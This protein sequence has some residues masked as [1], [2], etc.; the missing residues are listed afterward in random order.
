MK[1]VCSVLLVVSLLLMPLSA[2][3][4][5]GDNKDLSIL[6]SST[7]YGNYADYTAARLTEL[8]GLNINLEYNAKAHEVLQPQIIAGNP[9]DVVMAQQNFFDYFAAI[10][11][12]A[13]TPITKYLELPVEDSDQTVHAMANAS[14]IDSM[15]VNGEAYVMMSNMNISGICYDKAMFAKHGWAV[16]QSWDEFIALC[17]TIKTTTDIAPFIYPGMYPYYMSQFF[18]P[19]IAAVGRGTES[20]KDINN[21]K[22]GIWLS[23]EVRTSADRL[24]QMRDKGYFAKDLLSLNHT[25][26][27]MEFINGRVAMVS[28]GSWI[29]NEMGDN[30]PE[31]FELGFMVNPCGNAPDSEK[32]VQISGTLMGFP[33]AAKNHDWIG[34]FLQTYYSPASAVAVANQCAVVISPTAVTESAALRAALTPFVAECFDTTAQNTSIFMIYTIWYSEFFAGLQNQLTALISGE[35][36]APVFCE[37]M[38]KLAQGVRDDDFIAKYTLS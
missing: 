11:A 7:G 18:F 16:P 19:M 14:I 35:I 5:A 21:M 27:Q 6:W 4:A 34:E 15:R 2:A 1:K 31:D 25:S 26:A 28:C 9:P 33:S 29:Q 30:W 22:E 38:E 36:D 24:Q 23:D 13:F 12:G 20:I 32:F 10:D 3:Y 8:Y 37:N 17:E